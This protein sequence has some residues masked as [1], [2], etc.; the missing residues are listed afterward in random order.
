MRDRH[1]NTV[2]RRDDNGNIIADAA[3][4]PAPQIEHARL[5]LRFEAPQKEP[6]GYEDVV[7]SHPGAAAWEARAA[8]EDGATA[9]AAAG[10]KHDRY[11]PD[12]VRSGRLT[13]FLC[14]VAG[15]LER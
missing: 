7:V 1:G 3:G 5:D 9:E 14:G 11:P 13:G 6:Q 4:N 10:A 15:P 12:A 8:N 2:P